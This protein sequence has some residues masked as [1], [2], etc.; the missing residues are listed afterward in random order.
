MKIFSIININL[1]LYGEKNYK[2]DIY[3]SKKNNKR[4]FKNMKKKMKKNHQTAVR[5]FSANEKKNIIH[6]SNIEAYSDKLPKRYL[7]ELEGRLKLIKHKIENYSTDDAGNIDCFLDVFGDYVIYNEDRGKYYY[8]TGLLWH[9]DKGKKIELWAQTVMRMRRDLTFEKLKKLEEDDRTRALESHAKRCCNVRSVKAV[10]EGAKALLAYNDNIFD[11]KPYLLNTL[12]GTVNLKDGSIHQHNSKD[13]ITKLVPVRIGETGNPKL[14][15]K[16]M[17]DTFNEDEL[18]DYVL[19]LLGYCITG[20]TREQV[21]HFLVGNGANGKS[22]LISLILYLLQSYARVIPSKVL[23][24]AERAGAPSSEIAQLPHIRLVNCSEMNC[25]DVLNEGKIKV[26]SSGEVLAARELHCPAFTF[27]PEFKCLIDT[28]YLP[29]INGTDHGIWRRI[30]VIPFKHTVSKDKLNKNL[31]K[32]LKRE[33]EEILCLLIKYAV[34]YYKEGLEPCESVEKETKKY[35]RSQDT[36]GA[37]V[38]ACIKKEEGASVR[39]RELH[40]AY[41]EFC[42]EN[43]LTAKNETQFGKDFAALGYKKGKDKISRKYLDIK[44][45]PSA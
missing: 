5:K 37:F 25:T 4:K 32:E 23:V 41:E 40:K 28:N 44:L 16:F 38:E 14:F 12:S 30:R 6:G 39:A 33:K 20:E 45:K 26:M 10:V 2:E 34:K 24:S 19:R 31:L 36:I 35:R 3:M 15:K 1:C 11:K 9:E 17:E 18:I 21:I 43:F 42:E 22:T 7:E 13:Y 29:I 8:W 27:E